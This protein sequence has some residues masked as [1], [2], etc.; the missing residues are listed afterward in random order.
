[1]STTPEPVQLPVTQPCVCVLPGQEGRGPGTVWRCDTCGEVW[2][3]N[4]YAAARYTAATIYEHVLW[5]MLTI[6]FLWVP[7]LN[8]RWM[9]GQDPWREWR[10]VKALRRVAIVGTV[11][12]LV[13]AVPLMWA[14]LAIA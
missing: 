13:L 5:L 8:P 11:T 7:Y 14:N 12:L 2:V 3:L 4:P 10:R 6:P 1:M 9:F